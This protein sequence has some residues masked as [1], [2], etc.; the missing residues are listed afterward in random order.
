MDTL[1]CRCIGVI[2]DPLTL[3]SEAVE[4]T[5][6][7]NYGSDSLLMLAEGFFRQA[8]VARSRY[9]PVVGAEGSG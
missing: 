6:S 4:R 5:V 3:C 9:V 2:E 8:V 1:L 7:V